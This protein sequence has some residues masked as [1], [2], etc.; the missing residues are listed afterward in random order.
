MSLEMPKT[1]FTRKMKFFLTPLQKLPIIWAIW[2]KQL[3]ATGL[4]K[5]PKVQ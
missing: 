2:A 5:L 3:F 1:D 4:E